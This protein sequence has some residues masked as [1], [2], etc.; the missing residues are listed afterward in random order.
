[1]VTLWDMRDPSGPRRLA[2]WRP[3][4]GAPTAL[5]VLAD[6]RVLASGSVNMLTVWDALGT[7]RSETVVAG[8]AES[9]I[10]HLDLDL[11]ETRVL[12]DSPSS[13][14][15]I[16][17]VDIATGATV[18]SFRALDPEQAESAV[19]PITWTTAL[20]PAGEVVAAYDL[21]GRGF[22]FDTDGTLTGTLTGGHTSLVTEAGFTP[23]GTVLSASVDGSLR[24]WDPVPAEEK[25]SGSMHDNLCRVFGGRIDADSWE[26]AFGD[27]DLD[28]PCSSSERPSYPSLTVGSSADVNAIPPVATPRTVLL[29]DTFD[30]S[31]SGFPTGEAPAGTGTVN[32]K[33]KNGRYRVELSGAGA[34][35]TVWS[36]VPVTGAADAW[37]VVATPIGGTGGDCGVTVTDGTDQVAVSVDRGGGT[38]R[39]SWFT[40]LGLS[41]SL[42]FPVPPEADGDLALV[43]DRG[44]LAVLVGGR[45]VATVSD[46][47]LGVPAAAGVAVVGDT[48]T[49]DFD[50]VTVTSVS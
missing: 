28:P 8:R 45:R 4:G 32:R 49:C 5:A 16:P 38:G 44:V 13:F 2:T 33:I 31:E 9:A 20:D 7:G 27:D 21:A 50:D 36:T 14:Q 3:N 37:A 30:S 47:N 26:V 42:D 40:R 12:L 6:G 48:A 1:V 11:A 34:D 10:Q 25:T 24:L 17:L 15:G 41:S 29:Q 46:P 23:D 19:I 43:G 22:V 18:A 39:I 35:F